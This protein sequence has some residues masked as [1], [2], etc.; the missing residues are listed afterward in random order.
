MALFE[1]GRQLQAK[2]QAP[3]AERIRPASFEEFV[4]Q[5]HIIAE[6]R[7]LRRAISADRLPSCIFW[8]P[9]GTCLV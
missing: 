3:L 8:G 2:Q 1:H 6:E 9:P 7:V 4:G 5:Q